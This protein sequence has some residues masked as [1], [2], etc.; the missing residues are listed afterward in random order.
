MARY[1]LRWASITDTKVPNES[2]HGDRKHDP[3]IVCHEKKPANVSMR[4]TRLLLG[5]KPT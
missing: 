4:I 3:T 5:R 2:P 1:A